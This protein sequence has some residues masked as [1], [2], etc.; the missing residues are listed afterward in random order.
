MIDTFLKRSPR[1]LIARE[2]HGTHKSDFCPSR[3]AMSI[4]T[5][6]VPCRSEQHAMQHLEL[7]PYFILS[8][9]R[10]YFAQVL[11]YWSIYSTWSKEFQPF[12]CNHLHGLILVVPLNS[13]IL[14]YSLAWGFSLFGSFSS[15]LTLSEANSNQPQ[16]RRRL[17]IT[18][19]GWRDTQWLW[20][21]LL[22]GQTYCTYFP[23]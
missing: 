8:V 5:N 22:H 9:Q 4:A 18:A 20:N 21:L 15:T 19:P 3:T 10:N 16:D 7:H 1:T 17:N 14:R 11:K 13:F 6:P 2:W 12:G 23:A